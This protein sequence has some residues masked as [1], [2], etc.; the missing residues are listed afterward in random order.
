MILAVLM[1]FEII[2]NVTSKVE[3]F[4][5]FKDFILVSLTCK[6]GAV[7]LLKFKFK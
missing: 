5:Q 1:L 6:N 7:K 3:V 2:Q 4:D